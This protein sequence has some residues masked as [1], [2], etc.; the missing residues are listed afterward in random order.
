MTEE[1]VAHH[2][3]MMQ[4]MQDGTAWI[5]STFGQQRRAFN[6]ENRKGNNSFTPVASVGWACDPFGHNP[7]MAYLIFIIFCSCCCC[8]LKETKIDMSSRSVVFPTCS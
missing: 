7:V 5:E 6:L 3:Q 4:V 1:A 2:E 8:F